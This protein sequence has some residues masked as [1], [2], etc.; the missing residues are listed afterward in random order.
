MLS[1]KP[2]SPSKAPPLMSGRQ[3]G[4]FNYT[5]KATKPY[6]TLE[7]FSSFFK[8]AG[9]D[10][11]APPTLNTPIQFR[12]LENGPKNNPTPFNVV[13]T[14]LL[15]EILEDASAVENGLV[16][17]TQPQD[18]NKHVLLATSTTTPDDNPIIKEEMMQALLS[19]SLRDKGS[20]IFAYT[21]TVCG[22]MRDSLSATFHLA[23]ANRNAA[24]ELAR[25]H[26]PL[27]GIAISI[28][29]KDRVEGDNRPGLDVQIGVRPGRQDHLD[30]LKKE[31]GKCNLLLDQRSGRTIGA[32]P[33]ETLPAWAVASITASN[34]DIN[35]HR[36]IVMTPTNLDVREHITDDWETN[37]CDA[38]SDALSNHNEVTDLSFTNGY[39]QEDGSFHIV[40]ASNEAAKA[41]VEH[42]IIKVFQPGDNGLDDSRALDFRATKFSM[43]STR[44]Q[45][46]KP[47]G[48]PRQHTT[49]EHKP[50]T[51]EG[52]AGAGAARHLTTVEGAEQDSRID[53]IL[54][55]LTTTNDNLEKLKVTVKDEIQASVKKT[56]T[57]ISDVSDYEI[58]SLTRSSANGI[59]LVMCLFTKMGEEERAPLNDMVLKEMMQAGG[60]D[61][62]DNNDNNDDEESAF[63]ELEDNPS[64]YSAEP[65][66]KK[67]KPSTS[68]TQ[69]PK[70]CRPTPP[71]EEHE[72]TTIARNTRAAYAASNSIVT[73]GDK[74]KLEA[75]RLKGLGKKPAASRAA[76]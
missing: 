40:V 7:T 21:N 57:H 70:M 74:Q 30:L 61:Y 13:T 35:R 47:R 27:N 20:S 56:C 17:L 24:W 34:N 66:Q 46:S 54:A 64:P 32:S 42:G 50:T 33:V 18:T 62:K 71:G 43:G 55:A 48:R 72:P 19:Q 5:Q 63:K 45:G 16:A 12:I 8:E 37:I 51:D 69:Q 73:Q 25:P 39:T 67:T 29:P 14:M 44:R 76:T 26:G 65:V 10:L 3:G 11:S 31:L 59:A 75:L 68:P 4:G 38:I 22:K 36:R 15:N 49:D 2:I 52:G 23:V 53:D 6:Y 28:W 9:A 60:F 58:E 1:L 41:I